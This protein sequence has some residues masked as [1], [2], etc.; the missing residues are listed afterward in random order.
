MIRQGDIRTKCKHINKNRILPFTFSS[1][2]LRNSSATLCAKIYWYI[3][4][5]MGNTANLFQGSLLINLGCLQQI[6]F[7]SI[8]SFSRFITPLSNWR[9]NIS[10]HIF[11]NSK[12]WI[13]NSF[14][15]CTD[16]LIVVFC[17][18]FLTCTYK[19]QCSK[20]AKNVQYLWWLLTL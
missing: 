10:F 15:Y 7:K 5:I 4:I 20:N 11:W 12:N 2:L 19:S 6:L 3:K 8:F 9:N 1:S 14:F 17:V 16:G 18:F 13:H